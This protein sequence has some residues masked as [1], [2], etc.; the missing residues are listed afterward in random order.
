MGKL[1][2]QSVFQRYLYLSTLILSLASCGGNSDSSSDTLRCAVRVE[3][4]QTANG[5]DIK[6]NENAVVFLDGTVEA[7]PSMYDSGES[8]SDVIRYRI[9]EGESF[10]LF[11]NSS[12]VRQISFGLVSGSKIELRNG[13]S[14]EFSNL[15]AGDYEL[16]LLPSTENLV[17]LGLRSDLCGSSTTRS[18]EGRLRAISTPG[19]YV[20]DLAGSE[21]VQPSIPPSALVNAASR[22]AYVIQM[23]KFVLNEYV[24][25][26]NDAFTWSVVS[27][28]LTGAYTT[29]YQAGSIFSGATPAEAFSVV[30]GEPVETDEDI[31]LGYLI[32]ETS[33]NFIG[34]SE[35]VEVTYM[36]TMSKA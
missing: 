24:F 16:E 7:D 35:P 9:E 25:E 10:T 36:Q 29:L 14:H 12:N 23:T 8:G 19:I 15:S 3:H 32:A 13:E 22:Q 18:K 33:C 26:V 30:I 20:A 6:L 17:A 28:A 31:L 21:I 27:T 4:A 34:A 2:N 1:H 11:L 5:K